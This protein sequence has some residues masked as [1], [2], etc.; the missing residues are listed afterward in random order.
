MILF[1]PRTNLIIFNFRICLLLVFNEN[2]R[3]SLM[4]AHIKKINFNFFLLSIG[5][6]PL[7][8]AYFIKKISI[9]CCYYSYYNVL[10]YYK[11]SLN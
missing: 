8:C 2:V 7:N 3:V 6:F 10:F 5:N 11:Q 9:Y 1:L 4:Y